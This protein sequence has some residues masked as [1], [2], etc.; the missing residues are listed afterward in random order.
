MAAPTTIDPDTELSAVNTI[1][2][3]IG[4]SPVTTL[5]VVSTV[6]NIST[7]QNPEISFV[8]NLLKECNI[9]VQNEGWHFNKEEHVIQEPDPVTGFISIPNNIL[10]MDYTSGLH[11]AT[12]LH[13][14][15]KDVVRRNGRLYDKV[16]HTDVFTADIYTNVVWLFEFEDLPSIFKRYITYKA[17]GRAA[18]QLISNAQLTKLLEAQEA[19]ARAACMEYECNQSDQSYLGYP[20]ESYHTSFQPFHALRR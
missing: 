5:G 19:S 4:Q 17:A 1:L 8:W 13:D 6:N 11:G 16:N 9:D 15:T 12:G 14:K 20:H 2:G 3:A 7:Y 10:R 18:T